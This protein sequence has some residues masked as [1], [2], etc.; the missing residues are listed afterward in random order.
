MRP[1]EPL[2]L[3]QTEAGAAQH[4]C[5]RDVAI[6]ALQQPVR[7]GS[8][9]KAARSRLLSD[10]QP[11]VSRLGGAAPLS[12]LRPFNPLLLLSRRAEVEASD[13]K[14]CLVVYFRLNAV[15]WGSG[16]GPGG[17]SRWIET[18]SSLVRPAAHGAALEDFLDAKLGRHASRAATA[19]SYLE[20]PDFEMPEIQEGEA[21]TEAQQAE[22]EMKTPRGLRWLRL[23][24]RGA[25]RSHFRRSWNASS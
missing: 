15:T 8:A 3:L 18:I 13:A 12:I 16:R 5:Y 20:D 9:A 10:L 23:R 6:E 4:R 2:P 22:M 1:L 19:P 14:R 25:S 7:Q 24:Y 21:Q 11:R 17:F